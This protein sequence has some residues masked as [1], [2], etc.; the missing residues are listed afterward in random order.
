MDNKYFD[1]LTTSE[2]FE[3]CGYILT[4]QTNDKI[5]FTDE[6]DFNNKVQN[7][8]MITFIIDANNHE[9]DG[10]DITSSVEHIDIRLH[11]AID[12]FINEHNK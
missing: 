7:P 3:S 4:A 12:A 2:K 10:Y 5:V 11:K 9:V 8:K 6:E 1:A